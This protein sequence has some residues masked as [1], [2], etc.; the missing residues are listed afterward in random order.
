MSYERAWVVGVFGRELVKRD[1]RE[2]GFQRRASVGCAD[3]ATESARNALR[4][5]KEIATPLA[6]AHMQRAV[7]F[8]AVSESRRK[9]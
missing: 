5:T 7:D 9:C 4:Y 1:G 6:L 3:K 2:N 8:F